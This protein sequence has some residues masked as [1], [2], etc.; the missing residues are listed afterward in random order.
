VDYPSTIFIRRGSTVTVLEAHFLD[1]LLL[2]LDLEEATR[3]NL[4]EVFL[5]KTSEEWE[6][7]AQERGLPLVTLRDVPQEKEETK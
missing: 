6:Q 3:E 7:W 1:N 2:E 4:E 5:H